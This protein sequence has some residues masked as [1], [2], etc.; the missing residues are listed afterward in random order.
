MADPLPPAGWYPDPTTVDQLRYWDGSVW[1]DHTAPMAGA[2]PSQLIATRR[3]IYGNDMLYIRLTDGTGVGRV[4]LGTGKIE[5]ERP[6]L[7]S[8]FDRAVA[9][10]RIEHGR[11]QTTT[12][13]GG[14]RSNP[15]FV[16][17]TQW[18]DL[19]TNRPGEAVRKM[20]IQVRQE[21]P[22]KAFL[23]RMLGIKTEERAWRVG[24][25]GEQEVA[26]RLA[27]LGDSWRVIHSVVLNDSGTDIDHVVIGPGG[28]YTLNTK[29]HLGCTVTLY[30][31]M[32]LVNGQKT[33]HLSK[34]RAEGIRA[35]R[36]LSDACGFPV[37]VAPVVV[38]MCSDFR[39]R[40]RPSEV[41]VVKRKEIRRWLQRRPIVLDPDAVSRIYELA[42]RESTWRR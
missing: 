30:D 36:R 33:N 32:I 5:I 28:V 35:T 3:N 2:Q 37:Q 24:A 1:T 16:D 13:S 38:V 17:D 18:R 4:N 9:A 21:A 39:V 10:W 7:H 29:N 27:R 23:G 34:S 31:R 11:G 41:H 22:V 6:D 20:A 12:G 25:D 15:N 14:K 19:A 42:R 40:G 26:R 8:E